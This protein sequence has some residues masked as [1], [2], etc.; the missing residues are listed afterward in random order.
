VSF[1]KQI[2]VATLN[3]KLIDELKS[4]FTALDHLLDY[5]EEKKNAHV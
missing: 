3:N 2:N 4:N 1:Q 5:A